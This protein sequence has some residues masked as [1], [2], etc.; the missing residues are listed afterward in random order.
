MGGLALNPSIC[1]AFMALLFMSEKGPDNSVIRS[2]LVGEDKCDRQQ[3][4]LRVPYNASYLATV[5]FLYVFLFFMY[6]R[7]KIFVKAHKFF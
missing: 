3:E 2:S 4:P 5:F 6:A 7:R 1:E